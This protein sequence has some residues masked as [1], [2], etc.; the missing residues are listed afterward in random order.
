MRSAAV[1][2]LAIALLAGGCGGQKRTIPTHTAESFLNQLDRIGSQFDSQACQGADA[3]ARS[4]ESQARQLSGRVDAEVK[5]NLVSG[6]ER[7]RTL[8][9]HDC[10]RPAPTNT[11]PTTPTPTTPT[12]T[13][14]TTTP[15]TT[16]PTPTTPTTPSPT[17]PTPPTTT[18]PGGGGG[19]TV[20]G[21]TG[22]AGAQSG[23]GQGD[24]G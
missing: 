3:K 21:T 6:I 15:T 13:T 22:A 14:P 2:C 12:T 19:V 24:G 17:T 16:T 20:P 23:Q 11:T 1:I 4:L 10:Q 7:L 8:M 5:R 9:A 18:P